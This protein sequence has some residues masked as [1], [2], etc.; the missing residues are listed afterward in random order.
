METL[1]PWGGASLDPKYLIGRVYV[2]NHLTLLQTKYRDFGSGELIMPFASNQLFKKKSNLN[3]LGSK[4][5][6]E[7]R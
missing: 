1:D 2:G 6:L 4:F 3:A 7:V 5:D